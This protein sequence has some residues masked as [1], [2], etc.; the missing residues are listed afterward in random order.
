MPTPPWRVRLAAHAS[1]LAESRAK[2]AA[3]Q[4]RQASE[5]QRVLQALRAER[6]L[7]EQR[8]RVAERRADRAEAALDDLR[9][10]LRTQE[11][12]RGIIEPPWREQSME[13]VAARLVRL[14]R[15]AVAMREWLHLRV[16]ERAIR[17]QRGQ[18]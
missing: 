6:R 16:L 4:A 2:T 11:G 18:E 9:A 17:A 10:Q 3:R 13:V 14:D 1:A 5:R 12:R 7:A 15:E 8:A